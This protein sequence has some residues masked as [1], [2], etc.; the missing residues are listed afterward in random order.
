MQTLDQ[1]MEE[2]R[3]GTDPK[4]VLRKLKTIEESTHENRKKID[5]SNYL[6][7]NSKRVFR[8][9][10]GLKK[11][12]EFI[13]YCNTCKDS[14]PKVALK[15]GVSHGV[16]LRARKEREVFT[17]VHRKVHRLLKER[18]ELYLDKKNK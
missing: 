3:Q 2:I 18:G 14:S 4:S 8:K 10:G 9:L 17:N 16:V 12:L 7:Y 1:Q 11:V 5:Q 13:D 15:F 6:N